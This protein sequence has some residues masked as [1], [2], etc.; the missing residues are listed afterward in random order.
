MRGIL[1]FFILISAFASCN[2]LSE[3]TIPGVEEILVDFK[4]GEKLPFDSIIDKTE[5]V[6]L[7]T[8]GDNFIG[9]IS[10]ILFADTLL[11]IIDRETTKSI[12]VFDR[13]GNFRHKI[14]QLV[15][16]LLN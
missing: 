3:I 11:F 14:G 13:N 2:R 8:T 4:N 16:Y 1:L 5:Y 15:P 9:R 7:E 12:H 10:Q 6:K